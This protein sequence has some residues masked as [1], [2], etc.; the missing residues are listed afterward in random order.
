M[1][2]AHLHPQ[3][4]RSNGDVVVR[5][6]PRRPDLLHDARHVCAERCAPLHAPP[7]VLQLQSG[8]RL[9]FLHATS[10]C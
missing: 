10:K 1:I 8:E 3:Q 4:V 2:M 6:R 9:Q 7:H 5:R